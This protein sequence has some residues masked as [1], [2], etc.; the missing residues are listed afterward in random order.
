MKPGWLVGVVG[1]AFLCVG[2]G[3][4]GA[5]TPA[6][7][8]PPLA[9]APEAPAPAPEPAPAVR[10]TPVVTPTVATEAPVVTRTVE[11]PAVRREAPARRAVAPVAKPKP[12][13]AATPK[14]K[15]VAAARPEQT[16]DRPLLPLPAA[17]EVAAAAERFERGPLALA[18]GGLAFVAFGGAVVLLAARRQLVELAR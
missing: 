9:V 2:V 5:A 18:G 10:Q 16:H 7:D 11:T 3:S 17:A 15:Q 13:P 14:R 4:T 1:V 12:K 6:P 8:A